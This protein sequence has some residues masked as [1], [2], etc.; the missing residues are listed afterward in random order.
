MFSVAMGPRT[1]RFWRRRPG[2]AFWIRIKMR[3]QRKPVWREEMGVEMQRDSDHLR[4]KSVTL[5]SSSQC[6]SL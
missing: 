3:K 1:E 4:T 5:F 6:G 2:M